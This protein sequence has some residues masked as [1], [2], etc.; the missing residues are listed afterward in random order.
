MCHPCPDALALGCM[1]AYVTVSHPEQGWSLLGNGIA[2]FGD[3]GALLPADRKSSG[4]RAA[5]AGRGLTGRL[6]NRGKRP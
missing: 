6:R 3:A 4:L 1:A 5:A 2:T